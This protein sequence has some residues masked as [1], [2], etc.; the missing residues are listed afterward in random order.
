MIFQPAMLGCQ[1]AKE[2]ILNND[3]RGS[4]AYSNCHN[5]NLQVD[6][7]LKPTG[8]ETSCRR[9]NHKNAWQS[10]KNLY[11]I[12]YS[13]HLASTTD[14]YETYVPNMVSWINSK[15]CRSILHIQ[16][17]QPNYLIPNIRTHHGKKNKALSLA[18]ISWLLTVWS[19]GIHLAFMA[20]NPVVSGW[21]PPFGW[22][23]DYL[24]FL[25]WR[26]SKK[27]KRNT[28]DARILRESSK[29]TLLG[30]LR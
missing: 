29:E 7:H 2:G 9:K 25:S 1:R 21:S 15:K 3:Q 10:N 20:K 6:T 5:D 13:Q 18:V 16:I 14:R 26:R 19:W 12:L 17:S 27:A 28:L 22:L 4:L 11:T 23:H 30:T 8:K 24:R